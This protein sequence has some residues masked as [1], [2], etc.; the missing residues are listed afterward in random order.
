M[1]SDAEMLLPSF[2]RIAS[3]IFSSTPT[4]MSSGPAPAM[5]NNRF[6]MA[7]AAL[8]VRSSRWLE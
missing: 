5:A 6:D 1:T 7:M 4:S 3:T 2:L 8:C